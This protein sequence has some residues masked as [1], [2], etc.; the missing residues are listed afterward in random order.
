MAPL[1]LNLADDDADTVIVGTNIPEAPFEDFAA[2]SPAE[3]TERELRHLTH[4]LRYARGQ[5]A[6]AFAVVNYPA[7][8]ANLIQQLRTA[9]APY[10]LQARVIALAA[11][12]APVIA[13][14]LQCDLTPDLSPDHLLSLDFLAPNVNTLW[15]TEVEQV[16]ASANPEVALQYFNHYRERFAAF[17]C[18]LVFWLPEY[19]YRLVAEQAVDF[20]HWRTGVF[21]FP[22]EQAV[23]F[24][25]P[26]GKPLRALKNLSHAQKNA[27]RQLLQASLADYGEATPVQQHL[28]SRTLWEIGQ[29][30]M[31]L[32]AEREA[33]ALYEQSLALT[34]TLSDK[35]GSA[36]NLV[37]LGYL[38]KATNLVEA[39]KLLTEGLNLADAVNAWHIVLVATANLVDVAQLQGAPEKLKPLIPQGLQVAKGL[40]DHYTIT[41]LQGCQAFYTGRVSEAAQLFAQSLALAEANNDFSAQAASLTYT[42]YFAEKQGNFAGAQAALARSQELFNH[43]GLARDLRWVQDYQT[44]LAA[45]FDSAPAKPPAPTLKKRPA[46]VLQS[47]PA[48]LGG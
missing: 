47:T 39:E 48:Q 18:P 44:A 23:F 3:Q 36:R 9:I 1:P 20:W 7:Q 2:L 46:A 6:L 34:Q 13:E 28:R 38:A 10:G 17:R 32:G 19:A 11:E 45:A 8:R 25:R 29:L 16:L 5:F 12:D 43:L 26:I 14:R 37:N 31:Q 24:P 30:H 21:M 33:Q 27:R 22:S 41:L 42:A 15:L 4:F 35:A 40:K